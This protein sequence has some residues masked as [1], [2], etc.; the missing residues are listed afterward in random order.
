[1]SDLREGRVQ[2]ILGELETKSWESA[3]I[4]QGPR[5]PKHTPLCIKELFEHNC[6]SLLIISTYLP[7]DESIGNAIVGS[8]LSD[9]EK[10]NC[11]PSGRVV[12][13]FINPP[14]KVEFS[15]FWTTNFWNQN[16]QRL[17]SFI[18][19]E[20]A[21]KLGIKFSLKC[22]SDSLFMRSNVCSYLTELCSIPVIDGKLKH[23]VVVGEFNTINPVFFRES[24]K[25]GKYHVCDFWFFSSTHE[26]MR[27][28]DIRPGCRWDNGRGFPSFSAVETHL[29]EL[30][31]LESELDCESLEQ[32]IAQYMVVASREKVG[33]ITLKL[34]SYEHCVVKMS[35]RHQQLNL[36]PGMVSHA[37]WKAMSESIRQREKGL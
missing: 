18:G 5:H 3:I 4:L 14:N 15:D 20:Y 31:I 1:M 11:L 16:L 29:A 33:F 28:F 10:T 34:Q 9:F 24:K 13:L 7:D 35:K 6:D 12:Y 32:L 26:L 2:A 19:L 23:R 22:R 17:S 27:Y 36:R 30:W 25:L 8:H 21:E 37:E